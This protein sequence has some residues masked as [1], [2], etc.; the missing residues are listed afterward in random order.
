MNNDI[1]YFH[2]SLDIDRPNRPDMK[3]DNAVSY[4]DFLACDLRF[5]NNTQNNITGIFLFIGAIHMFRIE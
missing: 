3:R 5:I 1:L 2:N 4:F